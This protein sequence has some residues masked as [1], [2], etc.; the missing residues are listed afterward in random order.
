MAVNQTDTFESGFG[1]WINVTGDQRDWTRTSSG[2]PSSGTG[3]SGA[4]SGSFYVFCE[5]SS[6]AVAGNTYILQSNEFDASSNVD[7]NV[8]FYLHARSVEP[9]STIVLQAWDGSSW[10]E[11]WSLTGPNGATADGLN[12]IFYSVPIDSKVYSN[13]DFK[14]RFIVTIQ[15]PTAWRNDYALDTIQITANDAIAGDSSNIP[16]N[17]DLTIAPQSPGAEFTPPPIPDSYRELQ[18]YSQAI[19]FW[20]LD[21]SSGNFV[22]ST[23]NG[24]TLFVDAGT[25]TYS[26]AGLLPAEGSSVSQNPTAKAS[27]GGQVAPYTQPR[28]IEFWINTALPANSG[29]YKKIFTTA[30][31]EYAGTTAVLTHDGRII[32]TSISSGNSRWTGGEVSGAGIISSNTTHHVVII[33]EDFGHRRIYVDGVLAHNFSQANTDAFGGFGAASFAIGNFLINSNITSAWSS[34]TTDVGGVDNIDEIAVYSRVLTQEEVELHWDA[35]AV[36][37][38]AISEIPSNSISIVAQGVIVHDSE[39]SDINETLSIPIE[40]SVPQIVVQNPNENISVLGEPWNIELI[41]YGVQQINSGNPESNIPHSHIEITATSNHVIF[42]GVPGSESVPDMSPVMFPTVGFDDGSGA[43]ISWY[44]TENIYANDDLVAGQN[45]SVGSANVSTNYGWLHA[46]G[47]NFGLPS[48]GTIVGIEAAFNVFRVG[49]TTGDLRV[50]DKRVIVEGVREGNTIGA[51]SLLSTNVH[52]TFVFGGQNE[53]W[54]LVDLTTE[55]V[56]HPDFG[57]AI[58]IWG[59]TAATNRIARCDYISLKVWYLNPHWVTNVP[60]AHIDIGSPSIGTDYTTVELIEDDEGLPPSINIPIE[61]TV[62]TFDNTPV[63]NKDVYDLKIDE[64]LPIRHYPLQ[65]A[66]GVFKC[67][68]NKLNEISTIGTPVHRAWPIPIQNSRGLFLSEEAQLQITVPGL[69]AAWSG[70]SGGTL[71][72]IMMHELYNRNEARPFGL[73]DPS[74]PTTEQFWIDPAWESTISHRVSYDFVFMGG[75]ATIGTTQVRRSAWHHWMLIS[76]GTTITVYINNVEVASGV[77]N[78]SNLADIIYFCAP[79]GSAQYPRELLAKVTYFDRPLNTTER[80]D[81]YKAYIWAVAGGG[82]AGKRIS[83][84]YGNTLTHFFEGASYT[85]PQGYRYSTEGTVCDLAGSSIYYSAD[86]HSVPYMRL[87]GPTIYHPSPASAQRIVG[88]YGNSLPIS[89]F[90]SQFTISGWSTIRDAGLH[91][92]VLRIAS[93]GQEFVLRNDDAL[94]GDIYLRVNAVDY[95]P[96][97]S[98]NAGPGDN[99]NWWRSPGWTHFC[100][101]RGSGIVTV[102]VDGAQTWSGAVPDNNFDSVSTSRIFQLYD[103]SAGEGAHCLWQVHND[104]KDLAWVAAEY[105][106][107]QTILPELE[108]NYDA[109]HFQNS[110]LAVYHFHPD[111]QVGNTL[112]DLSGNDN[113]LTLEGGL[114]CEREGLQF[115][116]IDQRATRPPLITGGPFTVFALMW[117]GGED[118]YHSYNSGN[119]S[120][121]V[122]SGSST[123]KLLDGVFGFAWVCADGNDIPYI[124]TRTGNRADN[125]RVDTAST[126]QK[127][128]LVSL[129]QRYGGTASTSYWST[130]SQ[131]RYFGN[132][133]SPTESSRAEIANTA[134]YGPLQNQVFYI[135]YDPVS[136]VYKQT[137]IMFLAI[138]PSVTNL[139]FIDELTLE[140]LKFFRTFTTSQENSVDLGISAISVDTVVVEFDNREFLNP[141]IPTIEIQIQTNIVEFEVAEDPNQI[142]LVQETPH[143]PI[144]VTGPITT[145]KERRQSKLENFYITFMRYLRLDMESENEDIITATKHRTPRGFTTVIDSSRECST[146][147]AL[148]DPIIPNFPCK[149]RYF[150]G[151][152]HYEVPEY[153]FADNRTVMQANIWFKPTTVGETVGTWETHGSKILCSYDA[154]GERAGL[155]IAYHNSR[156]TIEFGA[157]VFTLDYPLTLDETHLLAFHIEWNG[158]NFIEVYIDSNKVLYQKGLTSTGIETNTRYTIGEDFKGYIGFIALSD[159]PI[160]DV[161]G[162]GSFADKKFL[163]GTWADG[164]PVDPVPD[165][166]MS[167]YIYSDE[168]PYR[169]ADFYYPMSGASPQRFG[170]NDTVEATFTNVTFDVDAQTERVQDRCVLMSNSTDGSILIETGDYAQTLLENVPTWVHVGNL[171]QAGNGHREMKIGFWLKWSSPVQRSGSDPIIELLRV[172]NPVNSANDIVVVLDLYEEEAGLTAI[173]ANSRKCRPGVWNYLVLHM[174]STFPTPDN[175]QE[176]MITVYLYINDF[177][178]VNEDNHYAFN[179]WDDDAVTEFTFKNTNA[180]ATTAANVQIMHVSYATGML[181]HSDDSLT[182]GGNAEWDEE[183]QTWLQNDF[184]Y[185]LKS[186]EKIRSSMREQEGIFY[187]YIEN[188]FWLNNSVFDMQSLRGIWRNGGVSSIEATE[189]GAGVTWGHP[190][191]IVGLPYSTFLENTQLGNGV[192]WGAVNSTGWIRIMSWASSGKTQVARIRNPSVAGTEVY[193]W[194]EAGTNNLYVELD[195][196]THGLI[197]TGSYEITLGAWNF[198]GFGYGIVSTP[199]NYG[200]NFYINGENLA[201]SHG[202]TVLAD[203]SPLVA[204]IG[205]DSPSSEGWTGYLGPHFQSSTL[206]FETHYVPA[207]TSGLP[208]PYQA[209][210]MSGDLFKMVC[211]CNDA[212]SGLPSCFINPGQMYWGNTPNENFRYEAGPV[213]NFDYAV[214]FNAIN[215]NLVWIPT[216]GPPPVPKF[217]E[218]W[219]KILSWVD[220]DAILMNIGRRG[221]SL[222]QF[223]AAGVRRSGVTSSIELYVRDVDGTYITQF[224]QPYPITV[225]EWYH[226]AFGHSVVADA[227]Y[228][229]VNGQIVGTIDEIPD[230]LTNRWD[231]D[232]PR[233]DFGNF[234]TVTDMLISY[235]GFSD[236]FEIN[237]FWANNHYQAGLRGDPKVPIDPQVIDLGEP[238]HITL[239]S[240]S[241]FS[242]SAPLSGVILPEVSVLIGTPAPDFERTVFRTVNLNSAVVNIVEQPIGAEFTEPPEID[243]PLIQIPIE[244]QNPSVFREDKKSVDLGISGISIET[245]EIGSSLTDNH[246]IQLSSVSVTL[247]TMELQFIR[248]NASIIELPSAG[249]QFNLLNPVAEYTGNTFVNLLQSSVSISP[250]RLRVI[251]TERHF[252]NLSTQNIPIDTDSVQA[253]VSNWTFSN[254]GAQGLQI[255]SQSIQ[256]TKEEHKVIQIGSVVVPISPQKPQAD[257]T[258]STDKREVYNIEM[259]LT[260]IHEE[261]LILTRFV[262]IQTTPMEI[263]F[264]LEIQR[265]LMVASSVTK[266]VTFVIDLRDP[267]LINSKINR[268]YDVEMLVGTEWNETIKAT[269]QED[270]RLNIARNYESKQVLSG[271]FRIGI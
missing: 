110:P 108:Y 23:G 104:V 37:V 88:N 259:M 227:S 167:R 241:L 228:L 196:H 117:L 90:N 65:E 107:G 48:G 17:N 246:M 151:T 187:E 54:G 232:Y 21:E 270:F 202:T 12:W 188:A 98:F 94:S 5:A 173:T 84:A 69:G 159:I 198:I 201:V 126:N 152:A 41:S 31:N 118:N 200:L 79:N 16:S 212:S 61:P 193:L 253:I 78:F 176:D 81:L 236:I 53:L 26:V 171:H 24:H 113:H 86:Y 242:T 237:P 140:P 7:F 25:Y 186:S 265:D 67:A 161:N 164:M 64:L 229:W 114:V 185:E 109:P 248:A 263:N 68:V 55:D 194:R 141:E 87:A 207:Y 116:G 124:Y 181:Y 271:K 91:G 15:G 249:L 19:A 133:R 234:A 73:G 115:N 52:S 199:N 93:T 182:G 77:P 119:F 150:D 13:T 174:R 235:A 247:N 208:I 97:Y 252:S 51:T 71:S 56:N 197:T 190:G 148:A 123:D 215:H 42:D 80:N 85:L 213:G 127:R 82:D 204:T 30:E 39:R 166:Y 142:V 156:I 238:P 49:G 89:E 165:K 231:P 217:M 220:A 96:V 112:L 251:T 36:A 189:H 226:I 184:V 120:F 60:A 125:V 136:N 105:Q 258:R 255:V 100:I 2:T 66:T 10:I 180:S 50:Y 154:L 260:P 245:R 206:S 134:S 195:H 106:I 103:S 225:G 46:T 256:A 3:P 11:E 205:A 240:P 221:G 33:A 169:N 130:G 38:A 29:E 129:S 183:E 262:E 244:T 160:T 121:D 47:F 139:D 63:M 175:S 149:S 75:D 266:E 155:C 137:K 170:G 261:A 179:Q 128:S 8:D 168:N 1:N 34:L 158:K 28:T 122:Y 243:M 224:E 219:I 214:R 163:T 157:D 146:L 101:T 145:R 32:T 222:P 131:N 14:L 20:T 210:E 45:S 230:S 138:Y 269:T 43:T 74:A 58:K 4:Q 250:R 18:T 6:P 268:T 162:V 264:N 135:G 35:R 102:Y 70:G 111:N 218:A 211:F 44:L 9:N 203:M 144:E 132:F 147:P 22:D 153:L 57:F 239:C 178:G 72:F 192:S 99:A 191:Y 233:S 254:I 216:S 223:A 177:T 83:E 257:T 59:T 95:G 27:T 40:T 92:K 267:I 62:I 172:P 76:N 209:Q 143:I